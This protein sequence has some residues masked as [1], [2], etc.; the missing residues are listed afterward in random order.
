M[1]VYLKLFRQI[2]RIQI[3]LKRNFYK[4][5]SNG[6][7]GNWLLNVW[8]YTALKS[9]LLLIGNVYPNDIMT[10]NFEVQ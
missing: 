1:F 6:Q 5:A 7:N 10:F 8:K 3:I 9:I 4:I 2:K